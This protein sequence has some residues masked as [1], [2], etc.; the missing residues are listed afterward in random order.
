MCGSIIV[1]TAGR[2]ADAV[3][4]TPANLHGSHWGVRGVR[5]WGGAVCRCA[6]ACL[7]PLCW[8]GLRVLALPRGPALACVRCRALPC[9]LC[10]VMWCV[11]PSGPAA[12]GLT[13]GRHLR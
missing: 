12:A 8:G 1:L 4:D 6:A 13:G 10:F 7:P 5:V 11:L 9:L 2:F 3:R